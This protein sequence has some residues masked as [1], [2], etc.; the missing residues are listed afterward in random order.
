MT[1]FDKHD[2]F[3]LLLWSKGSFFIVWY[4]SHTHSININRYLVLNLYFI[5]SPS[6]VSLHWQKIP[7]RCKE[8]LH[9][10]TQ[11][12]SSKTYNKIELLI[13]LKQQ[14]LILKSR[15]WTAGVFTFLVLK[16]LNSFYCHKLYY[17]GDLK[18]HF[19]LNMTHWY[20]T[21]VPYHFKI[22]YDHGVFLTSE[23]VFQAKWQPLWL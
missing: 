11:F 7:K 21:G 9:I 16:I 3:F 17:F 4:W 19:I 2:V 15:V 8:H 1:K 22:I 13:D 18:R 5:S 23:M 10:V 20:L 12:L 6:I 14:L